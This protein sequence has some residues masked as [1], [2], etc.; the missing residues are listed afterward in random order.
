MITAGEQVLLDGMSTIE[1]CLRAAIGFV[2]WMLGGR[3]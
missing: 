2:R 3:Q 1:E